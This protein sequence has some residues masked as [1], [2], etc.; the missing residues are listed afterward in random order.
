MM[1]AAVDVLCRYGVSPLQESRPGKYVTGDKLTFA[2]V[3][4]F[5]QLSAMQCG[6]LE[7]EG[8]WVFQVCL[9]CQQKLS[10]P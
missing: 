5:C 9:S 4:M 8:S 3:A 6:W 7:G 10:L 2:D 1:L